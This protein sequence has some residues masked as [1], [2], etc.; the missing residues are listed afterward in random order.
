MKLICV[1]E[2]E[3][4]LKKIFEG[5]KIMKIKVWNGEKSIYDMKI[6]LDDKTLIT[7]SN[8]GLETLNI[9][10]SKNEKDK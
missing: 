1:N 2:D 8:N 7:I 3:K 9:E 5:K 4:L 10:V 6:F